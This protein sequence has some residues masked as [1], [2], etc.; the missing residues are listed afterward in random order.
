MFSKAKKDF[1]IN[2]FYLI[3][4]F[5]IIIFIFKLINLNFIFKKSNIVFLIVGFIEAGTMIIP[6]VSGTAILMMFG[7]YEFLLDLFSTNI[8]IGFLINFLIG[9]FI[10]SL[11]FIKL[12]AKLFNK[13]P[14]KTYWLVLNLT[15]FSLLFMLSS[16]LT[17][18][19]T[20]REFIL[21]IGLF[22]LGYKVFETF[23]NISI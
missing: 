6:G 1:K 17:S 18:V 8:N 9:L 20:T 12:M 11:F 7:C 14:E 5:I 23:N 4:I 13:Y 19:F 3:L 15:L 21:S 22:I 2:N 16:T 10:G